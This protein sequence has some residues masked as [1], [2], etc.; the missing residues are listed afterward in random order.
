MR[1]REQLA[2]SRFNV[3]PIKSLTIRMHDGSNIESALVAS[4]DF[5]GVDACTTKLIDM[6]DH[7]QILRVQNE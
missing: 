2:R 1:N 5:Q 7:I 4:L 3:S 6:L